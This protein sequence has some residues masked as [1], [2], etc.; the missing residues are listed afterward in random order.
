MVVAMLWLIESSSLWMLYVF[1]VAFGA[2]YGGLAPPTTAIVGDTFGVRH[3]GAIF[4][5]LEVGWVSGA[6]VGPALA[7]YIFD[8]TGRYYLAFWLAVIAA[9]IIVVLVLF[10]RVKP[11]NTRNRQPV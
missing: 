11:V 9:L 7:G 6:A 3:I 10:L 4:G 5:V 2:A 1:A 8:T